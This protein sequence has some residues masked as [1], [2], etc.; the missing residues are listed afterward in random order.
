MNNYLP[1][2]GIKQGGGGKAGASAAIT[3]ITACKTNIKLCKIMKKVHYD[4]A[5]VIRAISKKKG[6]NVKVND[7]IIEVLRN[8]TDVGNG[9]WGKIDYLVKVHNYIVLFV[10]GFNNK[11]NKIVNE[12]NNDVSTKVAKRERKLNMVIMTKNAMRKVKTK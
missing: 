7:K 5:S 12:E 11:S 6:V 10:K 9:T 2:R 4:E 1:L 8:Q 3:I